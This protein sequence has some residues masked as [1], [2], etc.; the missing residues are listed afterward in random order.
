MLAASMRVGVLEKEWIAGLTTRMGRAKRGNKGGGGEHVPNGP[1][2]KFIYL[3]C[4]WSNPG[5]QCAHRPCQASLWRCA[6][7]DDDA[8]VP[9]QYWALSMVV[10]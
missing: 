6:G 1:A 7:N 5:R 3:C 10:I 9:K 4:Q 2:F 8:Q